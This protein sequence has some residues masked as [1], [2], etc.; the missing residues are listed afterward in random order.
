MV[1]QRILKP[2]VLGSSPSGVTMTDNKVY[3]FIL[4]FAFLGMFDSCR[5]NRL[6]DRVDALEEQVENDSA[7]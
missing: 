3:I 6:A 4:V 7:L 5:I 2:L 1:E